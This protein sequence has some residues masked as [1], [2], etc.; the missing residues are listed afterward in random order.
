MVLRSH[1]TQIIYLIPSETVGITPSV[2]YTSRHRSHI[3]CRLLA[4]SN[5]VGKRK[6]VICTVATAHHF[7]ALTVYRGMQKARACAGKIQTVEHR[8]APGLLIK[9]A[10]KHA[11]PSPARCMRNTCRQVYNLPVRMKACRKRCRHIGY[12]RPVT[13]VT[14]VE[15]IASGQKR[16]WVDARLLIVISKTYIIIWRKIAVF[17]LTII[18]IAD[19]KASR[20]LPSAAGIRQFTQRP[21]LTRGLPVAHIVHVSRQCKSR[22]FAVVHGKQ[23][24]AIPSFTACSHVHITY[25]APVILLFQGHVNHQSLVAHVAFHQPTVLSLLII[26]TH[27]VHGIGRKVFQCFLC[28]AVKKVSSINQKRADCTSVHLNDTTI[29]RN[30]RQLSDQSVEHWAFTQVESVSI[31]H[32]RIATH[33]HFYLCSLYYNLV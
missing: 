4:E 3:L 9:L 25:K 28:V 29:K 22:L 16:L 2:A 15:I 33:H 20:R 30:T 17:V 14:E 27:F 6:T 18:I 8:D 26:H 10:R 12:T 1:G 11:V 19:A 32:H 24:C 23:S 7:V 31:I 21:I 5:A 13:A